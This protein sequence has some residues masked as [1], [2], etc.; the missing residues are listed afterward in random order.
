MSEKTWTECVEEMKAA[1]VFKKKIKKV[2]LD[3]RPNRLAYLDEKD[4]KYLDKLG[5]RS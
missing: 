1:G 3:V 4:E 5:Y 2:N